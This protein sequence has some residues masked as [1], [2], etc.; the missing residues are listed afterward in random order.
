MFGSNFFGNFGIPDFGYQG[1]DPQG[2][3]FG[4]NAEQS[5]NAA[6]SPAASNPLAGG[7][8][9]LGGAQSSLPSPNASPGP[10][11]A[12]PAAGIASPFGKPGL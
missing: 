8:L 7:P 2:G 5:Q 6:P 1:A 11:Q 12:P 9:A 10:A 4:G 3:Y